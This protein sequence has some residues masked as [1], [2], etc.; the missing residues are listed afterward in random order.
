MSNQSVFHTCL[1]PR[2]LFVNRGIKNIFYLIFKYTYPKIFYICNTPTS[3]YSNYI[4]H[5]SL[6]GW[7]TLTPSP[8]LALRDSLASLHSFS[9][10]KFSTATLK[11]RPCTN[12][13]K[14]KILTIFTQLS[15]NM[16]W[17]VHVYYICSTWVSNWSHVK[18]IILKYDPYESILMLN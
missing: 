11:V 8:R 4:L 5:M 2:K 12:R 3:L 9:V 6:V 15:K 17:S 10:M 1:W 13:I 7:M 18:Y 14:T 16:G